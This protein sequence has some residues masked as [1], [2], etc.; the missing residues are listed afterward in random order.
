MSREQEPEDSASVATI[1]ATSETAKCGLN[2]VRAAQQGAARY[3]EVAQQWRNTSPECLAG[4]LA[5][6]MHATTFNVDAAAKRLND[7][8]AVTG[9]ANGTPTAAADLTIMNGSKAVDAVQVKYHATPAGTTIHISDAKYDGMQRVVP[10]DQA[11][12]VRE[13]ASKRGVDGLGRRNYPDVAKNASDRIRSHGAESSPVSRAEALDAA[14]NTSRVAGDLVNGRIVCAVKSGAVMGGAVGGGVSAISNLVAYAKGKRS[15][16][17]ALVD[18]TK[19]T[20]VCAATGAG[21]SGAAVMVEAGLIRAGVG[22]LAGGAA[23]VAIGVTA[24]EMVKDVGRFVVGDIDGVQLAINA[25]K[26]VVKGGATWGGMEAGAMIGT[27][28]FPGFGTAVG[29]IIGGIGGALSASLLTEGAQR[30]WRG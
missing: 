25:G 11:A 2:S 18:V 28:I 19:D 30:A 23:P 21:V 17:D 10:S 5:E 1:G 7:L 9:A 22:A 14:K 8:K 12:R 26:N 6:E 20:A 27:K 16:K 13:L 24:V 15:G 4:R 29:G 3:Q